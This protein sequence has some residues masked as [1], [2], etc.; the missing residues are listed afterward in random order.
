M[1]KSNDEGLK[2]WSWMTV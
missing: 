1:D 2:H